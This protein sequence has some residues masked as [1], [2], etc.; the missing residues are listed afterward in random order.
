MAFRRFGTPIFLV[1]SLFSEV[2]SAHC[3]SCQ[4]DSSA[5]LVCRFVVSSCRF[6]VSLWRFVVSTCPLREATLREVVPDSMHSY[7]TFALFSLRAD[8]WRC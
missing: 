7:M 3:Q 4:F 6:V 8:S 5:G 2:D 1:D